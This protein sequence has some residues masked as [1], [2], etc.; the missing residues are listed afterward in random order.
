MRAHEMHVWIKSPYT[1]RIR[2][3][4]VIFIQKTN[5]IHT[6][7]ARYSEVCV[8]VVSELKLE[9]KILSSKLLC[10]MQDISGV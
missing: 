2:Y 9:T 5:E 6:S 8:P 7:V 1:V 4:A 3:I 10:C